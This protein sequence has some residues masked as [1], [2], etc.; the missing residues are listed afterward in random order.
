[1]KIVV[2]VVNSEKVKQLTA[3]IE[4]HGDRG[5]YEVHEGPRWHQL[6]QRPDST[7][8][9]SSMEQAGQLCD[10]QCIELQ[11]GL[12]ASAIRT[13][14]R[15]LMPSML[16]YA[17]DDV[18]YGF[19]SIVNN[20]PQIAM[21]IGGPHAM[22]IVLEPGPALPRVAVNQLVKNWS[23]LTAAFET[24]WTGGSYDQI[25]ELRKRIE[26]TT[27]AYEKLQKAKTEFEQAGG[28]KVNKAIADAGADKLR[29][30]IAGSLV[31]GGHTPMENE[32][33]FRNL[34]GVSIA[35][36]RAKG[37]TEDQI[38]EERRKKQMDDA[39]QTSAEHS[40]SSEGLECGKRAQEKA[41]RDMMKRLQTENPDML[42]QFPDFKK[43]LATSDPDIIKVEKEAE[44]KA[45]AAAAERKGEKEL[46]DVK[47]KEIED[48][49]KAIQERVQGEKAAR[50]QALEGEKAARIQTLEDER[51]AIQHDQRK[52][53]EGMAERR[54]LA[55]QHGQIMQGARSAT[56]YYQTGSRGEDAKALAKE[57]RD[58]R[59]ETNK[60]L[61]S[62]DAS[63]KK[64][65]RLTIPH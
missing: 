19:S 62:I 9:G 56:D 46:A 29:T 35:G 42:S 44:E 38:T 1:M 60:K 17:I 36:M 47:K 4:K 61:E 25:L 2:D 14:C 26:D 11:H 39:R 41:A 28:E 5:D 16:G 34:Q 32:E 23:E 37:A 40:K 45:K 21:A 15:G 49:K 12:K 20:I 63:L 54:E 13:A 58:Q 24:V 30:Q 18:Q 59:A 27:A 8:S 51:T 22:A 52:F 48:Q 64:E 31:A 65:R 3:E 7:C 55:N 50:I 33:D 57:A 53:D 10:R 6:P 43:Q